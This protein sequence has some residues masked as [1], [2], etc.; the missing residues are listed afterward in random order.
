MSLRSAAFGTLTT[1]GCTLLPPLVDPAQA[2]TE[3]PPG[4]HHKPSV[5]GAATVE[6][7]SFQPGLW[8]YRRT[9]TS[10]AAPAPRVS[11]LMKCADPSTEIRKKMADLGK[12]SCQFAPLAYRHHRYLSSWT[13]PTPLGPTRFRAVL[14]VR[15]T[16]G[17]T[18][19]SEMRTPEH[20][21]RQKIEATRIGDC[22]ASGLDAEFR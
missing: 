6:L 7:P 15:G 14:I 10:D 16:V 3:P 9:V 18:D 19:V 4:T 20:I 17:Y 22:P 2:I 5:L 12:R 8:Q 13:C 11:T 1:V 21:S